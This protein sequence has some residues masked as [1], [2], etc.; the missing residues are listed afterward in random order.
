MDL[1]FSVGRTNMIGLLSESGF[2]SGSRNPGYRQ[3]IEKI[4]R[5]D[6]EDAPSRVQISAEELVDDGSR[7]G[8]YGGE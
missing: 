6:G 1:D 4:A 7:N 5:K 2:V 8:D 3:G